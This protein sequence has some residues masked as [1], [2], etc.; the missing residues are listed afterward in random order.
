MRCPPEPVQQ[1]LTSFAKALATGLVCQPWDTAS[2]QRHLLHRLP[3]R[4][5][6]T[7]KA[8][9]MHLLQ[10]FPKSYA[11]ALAN[12]TR[13]LSEM[14]ETHRLW[15]FARKHGLALD[16]WLDP[17]R[18]LPAQAFADLDL[19]VL[20]T[21]E[22]LAD[23][24]GLSLSQLVRFSDV[25]GLSNQ[26]QNAFAPHYRF[27][28][29]PKARGGIRL[30]EEPKPVLKRLQ[31]RVL[32]GLL[33][34][35]PPHPASFGFVPGRNCQTA[36]ARHCGEA[37]VLSFD[38]QDFF[39]SV[40]AARVFGLFR[41]MGYPEPVA[42]H[43]TGLVTLITPPHVRARLGPGVQD[44]L[45]NRHLPQGAPT[46]PALANLS[47]FRLDQRL[48]ERAR[49]AG[50]TYTRYADDMTFSGDLGQLRP[51]CAQVPLIVADAGFRIHP[52]KTRL[53]RA[54]Q[55]QRVTGITVNQHINMPRRDFDRLKAALHQA[56]FDPDPATLAAL[57]GRI[58]WLESLNPHKGARLR[59]RLGAI[60]AA[61]GS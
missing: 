41:V 57:D 53:A 4:Y 23:W 21:P 26:T 45:T 52:G 59:A 38:L 42:R 17:P 8:L 16:A 51:L 11:P 44:L 13:A 35:V 54:H 47:L 50:L 3:K 32:T 10:R 29:I 14:S 1:N 34:P 25:R 43:L 37:A 49:V 39:P 46:S 60:R 33:N 31:R 22:A 18:C 19:P 58:A 9:A 28:L 15:R 24:L 48:S 6:K 36:A 55:H 12:L 2:L 30:I 56:A 5:E 27:H 40:P 20:A 7:G 61:K